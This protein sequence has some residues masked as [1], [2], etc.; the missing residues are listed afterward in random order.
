MSSEGNR[1]SDYE[2]SSDDSDVD[3][4]YCVDPRQ[5]QTDNS[6]LDE[7]QSLDGDN[8]YTA[9]VGVENADALFVKLYDLIRRGKISKERILY[10]YLNDAV[11]IMYDPF[12]KQDREV[13]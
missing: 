7:T 12:H 4:C 10:R 3:I 9:H 1:E 11:E 6:T 5:P 8:L 2:Q 13:V